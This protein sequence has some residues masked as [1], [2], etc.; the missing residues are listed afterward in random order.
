MVDGESALSKLKDEVKRY[1]IFVEVYWAIF[2]FKRYFE[3]YG[4][5]IKF[6]SETHVPRF[7]VLWKDRRFYCKDASPITQFDSQYIYHTAWAA[8]CLATIKPNS[9]IDISSFLYFSTIVSAFIQVKFYDFRPANV[10]LSNLTSERATITALP[11]EDES[12]KSLSCL[13]TVEHIGLGR[14]GDAIDPDGDLK[15]I[16]E[17][18]RVLALDGNLLFAVPI[19]KEAKI[20]F[21]GHR[22]YTYNQIVAYFKELKLVEFCLITDNPKLDIYIEN[23]NPKLTELCSYG[24]GCFWFMKG[25]E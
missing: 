5:W 22:I 21:N 6:K 14:Y 25:R 20:I 4:E 12:I 18:K 7:T 15:A 23:A 19:G 8:R 11:F 16:A 1:Q 13:H 2:T 24:C 17:L 3:I 10:N 9:H